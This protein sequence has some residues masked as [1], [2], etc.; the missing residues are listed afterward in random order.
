MSVVNKATVRRLY[1]EA[2]AQGKPE[3]VDEVLDANFVC[4]DPN[5]ETD[6]SHLHNKPLAGGTLGVHHRARGHSDR[7]RMVRDPSW[8]ALGTTDRLSGSGDRGGGGS[9]PA[10]P[11]WDRHDR[12]PWV[13][14]PRRPDPGGGDG[15]RV[16]WPAQRRT[17]RERQTAEERR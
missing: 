13:D 8:R 16:W 5:S 7:P 11:L 15:A 2:F 17:L 6:I 12:A 10:L 9:F 14:L 4:H 3:V 1:E